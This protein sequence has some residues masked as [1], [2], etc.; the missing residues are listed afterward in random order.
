M[1][2]RYFFRVP[3]SCTTYGNMSGTVYADNRE[4]AMNLIEN[5]E[6]DDESYDDSDSD[7]YNYDFDE[8]SLELEEGSEQQIRDIQCLSFVIYCCPSAAQKQKSQEF[9]SIPG[10][11]HN[12]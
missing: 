6:I 7:N 9:L 4:E 11:I 8:A 2:N 1:S 3:Y 10:F 5:R 12:I